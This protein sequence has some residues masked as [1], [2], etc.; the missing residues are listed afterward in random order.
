MMPDSQSGGLSR[1][2][3]VTPKDSDDRNENL[4]ARTGIEPASFPLTR[5]HSTVEL[6]RRSARSVRNCEVV[7]GTG[8]EPARLRLK[9]GLLDALHSPM[10][11]ECPASRNCCRVY[12][13]CSLPTRRNYARGS[14]SRCGSEFRLG[15][16][17]CRRNIVDKILRTIRAFVNKNRWP[18]ESTD[19]Q[20]RA[21]P[22]LGA[23]PAPYCCTP[24][25]VATKGPAGREVYVR[26]QRQR[27]SGGS[28]VLP[29]SSACRAKTDEGSRHRRALSLYS[30]QANGEVC[31]FIS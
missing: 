11:S 12:F 30:S 31:E 4:A 10:E 14:R 5:E 3:T 6:P 8:L 7:S 18:S 21:T 2:L 16:C 27:L 1:L 17:R 9:A 25:P 26:A 23:C 28:R 29:V 20:V 22:C 13:S 24:H 15:R 19:P